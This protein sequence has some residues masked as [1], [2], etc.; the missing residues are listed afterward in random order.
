MLLN[1]DGHIVQ[2][3]RIGCA[4]HYGMLHARTN[5]LLALCSNWPADHTHLQLVRSTGIIATHNSH[6]NELNAS[7]MLISII[8]QSEV[9]V[10]EVHTQYELS[11]SLCLEDASDICAQFCFICD[12]MHSLQYTYA[13]APQ[14]MTLA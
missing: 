9:S 1:I 14:L 5:S 12:H 6:R 13:C 7:A 2:A 4:S 10:M 8:H 3:H 11:G